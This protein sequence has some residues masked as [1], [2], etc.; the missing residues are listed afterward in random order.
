MTGVT[1]HAQSS[2]ASISGA[3]RDALGAPLSNVTIEAVH[4]P[5]GYRVH[6]VTSANGAFVLPTL[7]LGGPIAVTARRIGFAPAERTGLRLAIGARPDVQ[8]TLRQTAVQLSA[9]AVRADGT[10]GRVH[11]IGGGTRIDRQAIAAF[12]VPDRNFSNLATLSPMAGAQLSLG[13][14]RW[15]STDIRVDGVQ[16][17][18]TLRAGEANGGPAAIPLDAVRE[19]EVNTA[20]FDAGQGRQGGGYIAAV[21]R[22][23]TNDGEGGIFTSYRSQDLSAN[24]DYQGRT[25][26]ARAARVQ[27]SGISAGGPIIR[28]VAHFFAAYERQDSDEPLFT[29]DVATPRAQLAAGINTDSL[30]RVADILSRLYGTATG[31][32]QLGRLERKPV[33]Q[34]ALA[35]LDW[36]LSGTDHLTVRGTASSWNSPLSGG[37]DQPITFRE[38]RSNFAS[39]ENQIAAI[40]FSALGRTTRNEAQLAYSTS[41][42]ALTPVSPGVPRGFVQVRSRLPDGTTGNATIQFGGNR[43]A[44]DQSREWSLAFRDQLSSD[45]GQW[46]FSVGTD[47]VLT[48]AH[49]LIAESQSGLFVFPSIAALEARQPDRF[50]RTVPTA[51]AAPVTEQRVLELGAFAQAEWRATRQLTVT[52]GLRWDGSAFLTAPVRQ[53]AIDTAFDVRTNHAPSDWRQW[54]PRAEAVWRIDATGRHVLRI[55]AGRF[56]AQVPYYAQHNQLLYT[57]ARLTDV[58][59]R[60]TAVPTPDFGLYR[61]DPTRVPGAAAVAAAPYVNVVGNFRAP[62]FDKAILAWES[63]LSQQLSITL[64]SQ[65]VR[66]THQYQY[67]DR[68]LRAAAAFTLDNEANRGVFV[69]TATIPASTGTT[70]VRN[71]V[72]N[73]AYARVVALQSD[74]RATSVS[75]TAEATLRPLQRLRADVAYAWSRARD[76]STYGCC[77]ARTA[78]TFTP[79]VEDPRDLASAWSASDLDTR[80]RLIGSA[81]LSAP[82]GIE[83]ALRYRG[84]S[85]RPFSLVV[86]G[87]INGDEANGNDLAF[88][89]DPDDPRTDPAIATSMRKVL[90]TPANV[91][92]A[93]IRSHLGAVAARNAIAMPWTHRVDLRVLRN[94]RIA[95]RTNLGITVDL[96]NVGNLINRSWGAQ[97]LL[98]AGISTQNPVV[99]RVSLLRVTGFDPTLK[100][101]RYSVNESAGALP[102]AGDPYQAQIGVRVGW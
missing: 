89:F 16:S 36:Q 2:D 101:Y 65:F 76:N 99:N 1:A 29:G 93:Y 49:T 53:I 87:D 81:V 57:G 11:R 77:L 32:S 82:W 66:S 31:R 3:V 19:F 73:P 94:V 51:G 46:I 12:P 59:L 98:P 23:G 22:F 80:H 24:A 69:P 70:D 28:D 90:A 56:T 33:S 13:G 79:V 39:R 8:F 75:L 44:P 72:A 7:P 95:G 60:G 92:A 54:Q 25:R 102:K 41:R 14:M 21:T 83:L 20:T 30:A 85:G 45:R 34:S 18:N 15:T 74:A 37:V 78:T 84:Q 63:R 88:L 10:E 67:V 6:S 62:V 35:R 17:R 27:Q 40:L 61:T 26:A 100:R 5:T 58:D 55:G 42:R 9:V 48:R 97:Y 71:A 52:T 86:D 4:A 64:S 43:L 47:N 38:A 68:N 96:F 91:A 50:T